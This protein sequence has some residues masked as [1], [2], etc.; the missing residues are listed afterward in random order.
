MPRDGNFQNIGVSSA[1]WRMGTRTATAL[2]LP[3]RARGTPSMS[4]R[5]P[6]A[7]PAHPLSP[8]A[9]PGSEQQGWGRTQSSR[10]R[11]PQALSPS[12]TQ[13]PSC[14]AVCLCEPTRRGEEG[15][16]WLGNEI[17]TCSADGRLGRGGEAAGG[18]QLHARSARLA[19]V[20]RR[21]PHLAG[22]HLARGNGRP[23]AQ[24]A[25][26]PEEAPRGKAVNTG[27]GYSLLGGGGQHQGLPKPGTGVAAPSV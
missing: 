24:S 18:G 27:W 10:D 21:P 8:V 25:R 14:D 13:R 15:R 2:T 4:P 9:S 26:S 19:G 7:Q 23:K 6:H 20:R 5:P 3:Q 17:A 22:E 12:G 11:R 16:R 1:T